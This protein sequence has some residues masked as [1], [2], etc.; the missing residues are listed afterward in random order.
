MINVCILK[1]IGIL[2]KIHL[3]AGTCGV[4]SR[5][6]NFDLLF[7]GGM[8][9]GVDLRGDDGVDSLLDNKQNGCHSD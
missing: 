3:E 1:A 5:V 4:L 2:G 9:W 6:L 8:G 7:L